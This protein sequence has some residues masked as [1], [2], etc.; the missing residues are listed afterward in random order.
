MDP[1]SASIGRVALDNVAGRCGRESR[2]L[3]D[4]AGQRQPPLSLVANALTSVNTWAGWSVRAL[5]ESLASRTWTSCA[6]TLNSIATS[7]WRR[8][9]L[10]R[11]AAYVG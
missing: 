7:L 6:P 2:S 9:N 3:I 5:R 1:A 10:R 4:S 11:G 8:S